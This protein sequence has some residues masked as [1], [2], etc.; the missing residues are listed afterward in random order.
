MAKKKEN[1]ADGGL[2]NSESMSLD[3]KDSAKANTEAEIKSLK[4]ELSDKKESYL[5]LLADFDNYKKRNNALNAALKESITANVV[6]EFL[7]LAD[8]Y[9][10]ALKY[11]DEKSKTGVLMIYKQLIDIFARFNVKEMQPLGM[12]FDPEYHEA[13]ESVDAEGVEKGTIVEVL[14]K[15]YIFGEKTLRCA[16]VKVAK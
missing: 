3:V 1:G 2:K 9:E 6:E 13:V 11:L 4:D 15:G 12:Q 7:P 14:Q 5:R 10:L 8:N 16:M